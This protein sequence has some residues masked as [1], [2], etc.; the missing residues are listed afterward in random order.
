MNL[1][2]GFSFGIVTDEKMTRF[3]YFTFQQNANKIIML[4]LLV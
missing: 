2:T 3:T 1:T 4:L